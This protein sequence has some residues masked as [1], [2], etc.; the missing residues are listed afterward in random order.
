MIM[1]RPLAQVDSARL[2]PRIRRPSSIL[3]LWQFAWLRW[4]ALAV[5]F[6]VYALVSLEPFDWYLPTRLA[7]GATQIAD[8]WAF[9][10]PG[11]VLAKW[12]LAWLA[13]AREAETLELS[14]EVRPGTSQRAG[15]T[16]SQDIYTAHILSISENPYNSNLTIAQE[17]NDLVLRLRSEDTDSKGRRD[18]H[19][20][21]RLK[22][23]LFAGEWV[24][25]DLGIR[26]GRLTIAIDGQQELEAPL[27]PSVLATWNP[28]YDLALGNEVTCNRP[29]LGEIRNPVITAS[30]GFTDYGEAHQVN[31]PGVC[32]WPPPKLV[33]LAEL[34]PV[35]AALN[36]PMYLPL[37]CLLGLMVLRRSR[38]N[39]LALVLVVL[40]VSLTFEFAQVFL[41][42]RSPSIDDVIFNT[43]GGALG[44]WLGFRLAEH[45]AQWQPQR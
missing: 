43:L 15:R 31:R 40:S 21:A 28:D 6:A 11:I 17:G 8:G 10:T 9:P 44:I 3:A 7:N 41:T 30:D 24:A 14:L 35:D 45:A 19:P 27:P 34:D 2:K 38:R 25:I 33:P 22:N 18:G 4:S 13:S 23:V 36:L 16:H 12:P 39:F 5:L 37:G 1:E 32:A 42:S 20:V 29:W 26:P